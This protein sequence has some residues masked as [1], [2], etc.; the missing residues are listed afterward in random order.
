MASF[1]D[2]L[3]HIHSQISKPLLDVFLM[4]IQ[5]VLLG[6]M[7]NQK[8]GGSAGRV[9]GCDVQ[10]LTGLGWSL[11]ASIGMGVGTVIFTYKFLKWMAPPFGKMAAEEAQLEGELRYVG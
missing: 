4:S 8:A 7:H 1:C 6:R 11:P 2:H 5:L 9:A 10:E 3:A